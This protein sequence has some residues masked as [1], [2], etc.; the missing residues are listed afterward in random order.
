MVKCDKC[1]ESAV[2]ATDKTYCKNHFNDYFEKKVTDTIEKYKLIQPGDKIIVA[3]SGG[4]DSTTVLHL[5]QKY[6]GN[7]EALAIDEGIPG[8]RSITLQGLEKFTT[9]NKIPL[10][11]HSYKEEFG[12]SLTEALKL[13]T[14][15]SAC[16]VCGVLRRYLLNTKAR[17]FTKI[18]TGHNLDDEAQS[19]M[20]NLVKAQTQ[21]LSRLGP[22]SG[23]VQ[24]DKFVPRIKP[25]YFVTEKEVA[26]YS[27]INNLA[28][29]YTQC[30]NAK[31]SFRAKIRD[32]LNTYEATHRGAKKNLINNFI[33]KLPN[34]KST[35]ENDVMSH[36]LNCGEPSAKEICKACYLVQ[37]IQVATTKV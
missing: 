9:E 8:Y 18:A 20:M 13:R 22:V 32:V 29:R 31:R 36:C 14:D 27:F 24:D 28:P 26:V 34:L 17:G 6:Y 35:H 19:I 4:K 25:L 7:V 1:S 15:L 11:I 2:I 5:L 30:P 23:N 21:L 10:H 16:Y 37:S 3:S 33:E 12:F